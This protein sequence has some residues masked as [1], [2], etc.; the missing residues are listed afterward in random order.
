MGKSISALGAVKSLALLL[1]ATGVGM[2]SSLY[3]GNLPSILVAGLLTLMIAEDWME[4]TIDVPKLIVMTAIL[5][6]GVQDRTM[7][8]LKYVFLWMLFRSCFLWLMRYEEPEETDIG[9]IGI[10]RIQTGFLPFFCA[11]FCLVGLFAFANGEVFSNIYYGYLAVSQEVAKSK[12]ILGA[13][14]GVLL[15]VLLLGEK[16]RREKTKTMDEIWPFGDG[17][18]WFL[19]AW[20]AAIDLGDFFLAFFVSQLMLLATYAMKFFIGGDLQNE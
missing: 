10:Q 19:A 15:V 6:Y 13:I 4:Q 8:V 11:S 3:I 16:R 2:F 7:F 5:L 9:P 18:V 17:D 14:F 1:I 12:E 20:G